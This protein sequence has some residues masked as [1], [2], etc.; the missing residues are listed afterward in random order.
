MNGQV[1]DDLTYNQWLRQQS[2]DIQNEALGPRRGALFRKGDLSV[3]QF[4]T[5]RGRTLTLKELRQREPDAFE[6]AGL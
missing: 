3:T 5:R 6:A 2:V 1:P 4:T